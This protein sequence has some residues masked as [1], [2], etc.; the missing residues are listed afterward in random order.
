[1]PRNPSRNEPLSRRAALSGATLRPQSRPYLLIRALPA[2]L[3]RTTH[4]TPT[5]RPRPGTSSLTTQAKVDRMADKEQGVGNRLVIVE[6]PAKA[7][8]ISGYLG[9]GYTVASSV[10]HIRDLPNRASE[11][12]KEK[13]AKYG[14]MG[15]AIEDEFEPLYLVDKDKKRTVDDLKKQLKQ[16]DELL[17]A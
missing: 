3:P 6:S 15:V 17:L 12:P 7:R 8:T 1:M 11:I 4:R 5:T 14:T 2:S 13:R 9:A 16:A 10:G